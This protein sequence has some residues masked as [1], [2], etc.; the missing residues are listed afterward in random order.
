[1]RKRGSV[2]QL[3]VFA[4]YN[5]NSVRAG[6]LWLLFHKQLLAQRKKNLQ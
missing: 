4:V 2:F 5:Q 6:L 3:L 1:M